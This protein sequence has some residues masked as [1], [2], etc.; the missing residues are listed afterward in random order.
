MQKW[1]KKQLTGNW[2]GKH[3]VALIYLKFHHTRTWIYFFFPSISLFFGKN[4]EYKEETDRSIKEN[5]YCKVLLAQ[6]SKTA[7]K[8]F[9]WNTETIL[10]A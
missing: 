3:C 8:A 10:R 1:F 6:K 7:N 4:I 5:L 9:S 2:T